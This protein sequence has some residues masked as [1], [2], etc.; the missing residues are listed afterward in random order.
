MT[1]QKTNTKTISVKNGKIIKA[2]HHG[3]SY[4]CPICKYTSEK[5][6]LFIFEGKEY[7]FCNKCYLDFLIKTLAQ[8]EEIPTK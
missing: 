7:R 5:T 4:Q 2:D 6:F 8:V 3:K 1:K